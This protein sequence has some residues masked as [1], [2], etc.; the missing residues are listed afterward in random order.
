MQ[1]AISLPQGGLRRNALALASATLLGATGSVH[2]FQIEA[3]P[4]WRVNF[5]NTVLYNLG[6]R[7]RSVD[8]RIGSDPT[9][10]E[11]DYRF[12]D[13]GD[14]VTNRISLLSEFDAVYQRN[15]G[16]RVSA[17]GWKDFAYDDK[18]RQ[19]P[20][21]YVP[22]IPN[23]FPG[24]PYPTNYNNGE[25][26]SY[27][28]RYQVQG[29]ELLD[30]FVFANFDLGGR[31]A[32]LRFGKLA[33]FWGNALF[34]SS[35]GISFSQSA[36]DNIKQLTAPG[37]Q[38]KELAMPRAQINFS[39]QLTNDLQMGAQ[40]FLQWQ[41]DRFP[42]GGTFLA[43][44]TDFLFEGPDRFG[45]MDTLT[46][47][48]VPGAVPITRAASTRP[49]NV[50][51]NFGLQAKWS[52]AALDGTLGFY[53]RQ[54]DETTPWNP[55]FGMAMTQTGPSFYYRLAYPEKVKM[56]AVSLDK[57]I[58]GASVGLEMSYR[59][60]TGL[61]TN[62]AVPLLTTQAPSATD[63]DSIRGARGDTL[64]FVANALSLLD[65]TALY[66]TGTALAEIAVIHKLK[67]T[68]Q[69]DR[70]QGEG[71]AACDAAAAQA[72]VTT[73][74]GRYTGCSSDTAVVIGG[75]FEPQWLQA[76]P[77]WDL[78]AP[79]FG[80]YGLHGNAASNGVAVKQG[81]LMYGL[82]FKAVLQQRYNFTLQ[83]NGYHGRTTGTSATPAG[84]EFYATGNN[85]YRFN[86]RGWLSFTFSST[87]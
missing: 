64:N 9:L 2:A 43:P 25:Y 7:M 77:G 48:G 47:L 16:F 68:D 78:S 54:F 87:F 40:Y 27:T 19:N 36:S 55:I 15:F 69:A 45:L 46:A 22:A 13:R 11:S 31:P 34:F 81:D 75:M 49:G 72:G 12:P 80:M 17:S 20:N 56:L 28:K 51:G 35:A 6:S 76:L 59:K 4:D 70:Y 62:G 18:P 8:P 38:A 73:G 66:N 1:K 33:Q 67:V 10:Q 53:Y 71:T 84:A 3:G 61:N 23:I 63:F 26:S 42:S 52:P 41:A 65:R 14:I 21:Y 85:L 86:D 37:T 29:G 44:A 50:N 74:G 79:M 57:Q 30:A 58:G 5:D 82:G 83:Y 24:A 39:T 60:G 32:T